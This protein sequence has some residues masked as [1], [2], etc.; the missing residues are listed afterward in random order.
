[1][2]G[3]PGHLAIGLAARPVAKSPP[4]ALLA[5]TSPTSRSCLNVDPIP[6]LLAWNDAALVYF[7]A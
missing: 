7:A 3:L 1:M 4:W 6:A 5:A 2:M